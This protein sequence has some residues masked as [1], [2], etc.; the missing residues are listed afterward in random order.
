MRL[1]PYFR[2]LMLLSHAYG[3]S[4]QQKMVENGKLEQLLLRLQLVLVSMMQN[5]NFRYT[6][7]GTKVNIIFFLSI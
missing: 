6:A 5:T 3:Q 7:L 1:H 2:G 4:N